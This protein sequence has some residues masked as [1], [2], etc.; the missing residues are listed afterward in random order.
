M[1]WFT[2]WFKKTPPQPPVPTL[3][4]GAV[5]QLREWESRRPALEARDREISRSVDR[6]ILAGVVIATTGL[7]LFGDD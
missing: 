5:A 2:R 1:N 3:S 7:A 4:P 6:D